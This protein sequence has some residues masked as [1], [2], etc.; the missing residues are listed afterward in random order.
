MLALLGVAHAVA[1]LHP[2][3]QAEDGQ[4]AE[5]KYQAMLA[6]AKAD[7]ESTDWP[8]LRFAYADRPSF[9]PTVAN[10]GRKA[11]H[12][13]L[14]ASDWQ[15]LLAAANKLIDIDF[16]DGEAHMAAG[17]AYGKLGGQPDDEKREHAIAAHLFRSIRPNGNGKSFEQ[18]FVVIGVAEEY[19]AV[20]SVLGRRM[21]HQ[22]LVS[23]PDHLGY[24]VLE[25][26]GRDGDKV[27]YY[28][29]I[30]RVLAAES[31]MLRP[32]DKP[33]NP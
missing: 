17:T 12:A 14:A 32:K 31:R 30:G 7:P 24:D 16:V 3:A 25:T 1:F 8:A 11:M 29:Q 15:G 13:A 20:V 22:S 28:F 10:E 19:E 18:A 5:A 4:D 6:A 2:A 27:T 23:G 9:L 33:P 21:V 26:T